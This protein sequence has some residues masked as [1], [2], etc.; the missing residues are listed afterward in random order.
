MFPV[1]EKKKKKK[2]ERPTALGRLF[3]VRYNDIGN[4]CCV[5]L[6][7]HSNRNCVFQLNPRGEKREPYGEDENVSTIGENNSS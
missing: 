3:S 7:T 6:L 2:K 1:N 4:Q 5:S